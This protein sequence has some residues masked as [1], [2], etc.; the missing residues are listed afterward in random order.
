MPEIDNENIRKLH[1]Y[2]YRMLYEVKADHNYVLAVVHKRQDF[3][4]KDLP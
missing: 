3:R 2:S 1:L 4:P